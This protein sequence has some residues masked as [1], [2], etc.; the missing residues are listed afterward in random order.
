MRA[1]LVLVVRYNFVYSEQCASSLLRE[2]H[3]SHRRDVFVNE[4]QLNRCVTRVP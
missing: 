4:L 3:F 2:K 1:Q